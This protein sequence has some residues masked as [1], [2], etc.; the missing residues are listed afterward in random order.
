L[1]VV[2][3]EPTRS[4]IEPLVEAL[5]RPAFQFAM[6]LTRDAG[7]AEEIVQESFVRAWE[8]PRTP[9]EMPAFRAFLFR[10]VLNLVRDHYRR[11]SR[12]QRLK[13]WEQAPQ[14]PV[15]EAEQ[16]M[17][18]AQVADAIRRLSARER[19]ALYLRF[20]Q[21]ASYD[22]ISAVMQ[23][24]ESTGRVLVHRALTRLRTRFKAVGL[25]PERS[26]T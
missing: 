23:V 21:D 4:W 8:F 22:E 15:R 19:E 2:L 18:D 5:G 13:V 11:Q 16:H 24:S 9:R 26:K 25:F 3:L 1:E 7:D 10:T 12:W 20:F 14:D 6:A 17:G